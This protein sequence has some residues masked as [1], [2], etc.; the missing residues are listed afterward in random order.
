MLSKSVFPLG[1]VVPLV[2][3]V[4]DD[5]GCLV[6][7]SSATVTITLPNGTT[8]TPTLTNT[9][10]GVYTCNYPTAATGRYVAVFTATGTYAGTQ[11]DVFDVQA[12]TGS[13]VTLTDVKAYLGQTSWSDT[14]IQRALDAERA[15][16]ARI[17]NTNDYGPDLREALLRRCARNLAARAVPIATYTSFDGGGT[18]TRVPTTDPEIIRLEAPYRRL[19]MG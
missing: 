9:Q 16:Q 19:V 2:F 10:T 3:E 12:L 8:T 7:A 6:A 18:A 15:A 1:D 17:C 11:V 14:E 4:R 13:L 5:N